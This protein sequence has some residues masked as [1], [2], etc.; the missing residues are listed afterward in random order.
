MSNTKNKINAL[1]SKV[2]VRNSRVSLTVSSGEREQP[3]STQYNEIRQDCAF[4]LYNCYRFRSRY[5]LSG[6]N[7]VLEQTVLKRQVCAFLLRGFPI[8]SGPLHS[9]CSLRSRHLERLRWCDALHEGQHQRR[10][11]RRPLLGR[12]LVDDRRKGAR[13][14]VE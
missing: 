7:L 8:D 6:E 5:L 3:A 10:R 1:S 11:R 9:R 2:F 4:Y 12:P 14:D 13:Q